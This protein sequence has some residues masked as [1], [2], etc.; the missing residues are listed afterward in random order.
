MT[1]RATIEKSYMI[2]VALLTAMLTGFSGWFLYDGYVA[3]PRDRRIAQEFAQYKDQG[4]QKDWPAY[5]LSQ[6]WPD[7]SKGE[8]GRLHSDTDIL[9]QQILGY[10]L[11]PFGLLFLSNLIRLNGRWIEA[12]DQGLVTSWGQRV[13]FAQVTEFDKSRWKSKGIAV[14]KYAEPSGKARR[15]VLD[16]WKYHRQATTQLV[17]LVQSKINPELVTGEPPSLENV[18]GITP[19]GQTAGEQVSETEA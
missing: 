8:P 7:G 12:D 13:S 16:D 5:A 3:Y 17:E 2:R 1:P 11:L 10:A 14:V 19:Q 4:K 6:G 15:L 9:V 18:P